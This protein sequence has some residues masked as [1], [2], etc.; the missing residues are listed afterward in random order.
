MVGQA[1]GTQ[2]DSVALDA[3][4]QIT[5]QQGYIPRFGAVSL[6]RKILG[7]GQ[8]AEDQEEEEDGEQK[9]ET[10]SWVAVEGAEVWSE[11]DRIVTFT[12]ASILEPQT[13]Y[14]LRVNADRVTPPS[15]V[16]ECY[17]HL[18]SSAALSFT[19]QPL[20]AVD[21]TL[22]RSSITTQLN[23]S[24][25][26]SFAAFRRAVAEALQVGEERIRDLSVMPEEGA[27]NTDDVPIAEDLDV[28]QL[29]NGDHIRV[30]VEAVPVAIEG[31]FNFD[32]LAE[33]T[34]QWSTKLGKWIGRET[35]MNNATNQP[36]GIRISDVFRPRGLR[37][38][39][40]RA[41]GLWHTCGS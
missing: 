3:S 20:A 14:E 19:T 2:P 41:F 15:D 6:H 12:P 25:D 34:Q 16:S 4:L 23:Y 21:L 37:Y 11:D 29:R 9:N 40:Q 28:Q 33:C 36:T 17:R 39:L 32:G 38:C 24:T 10:V 26:R 8:A 31:N 22:H 1:A 18:M 35:R 7:P 13:D 27:A 5:F 30:T